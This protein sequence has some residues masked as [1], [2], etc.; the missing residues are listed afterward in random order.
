[1]QHL[2]LNFTLKIQE[3][4]QLVICKKIYSY[5]INVALQRHPKDIPFPNRKSSIS[6]RL[7]HS[8]GMLKYSHLHRQKLVYWSRW[9]RSECLVT[10]VTSKFN[11]IF[12]RFSL[13]YL[14][15]TQLFR[16]QPA[17]SVSSS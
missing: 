9:W 15:C 14:L 4:V 3:A 13:N 1:M 8:F 7:R 11:L 6:K 5:S 17:N 2:N 12:S 10:V 16:F